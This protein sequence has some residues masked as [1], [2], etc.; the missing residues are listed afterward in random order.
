VVSLVTVLVML[1]YSSC[2]V[3]ISLLV[4]QCLI[5]PA[6][7]ESTKPIDPKLHSDIR[8]IDRAE[9]DQQVPLSSVIYYILLSLPILTAKF[10]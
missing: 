3:D 6:V 5:K 2:H 1:S 10:C 8:A 7:K 4:P 9:F